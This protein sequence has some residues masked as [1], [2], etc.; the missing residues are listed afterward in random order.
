MTSY[1][2][3]GI[4]NLWRQ[5]GE[6]RILWPNPICRRPY[7]KYV[8]KALRILPVLAWCDVITLYRRTTGK[9]YIRAEDAAR[10]ADKIVDVVVDEFSKRKVD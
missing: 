7:L 4:R 6:G 8:W 10:A 3:Y 9:P 5:I 1:L 2:D